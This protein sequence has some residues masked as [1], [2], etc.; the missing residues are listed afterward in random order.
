MFWSVTYLSLANARGWGPSRLQNAAGSTARHA[1]QLL[2]NGLNATPSRRCA[3]FRASAA[4]DM[5][6]GELRITDGAFDGRRGLR[7]RV[8]KCL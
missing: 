4:R 3:R 8:L 5:T 7:C 2:G 1:R 6:H